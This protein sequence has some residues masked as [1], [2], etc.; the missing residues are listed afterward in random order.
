MNEVH[1][2]DGWVL[3]KFN[4][5]LKVFC[6]WSG[7]YLG[8]D[9]WRLNSKVRTVDMDEGTFVINSGGS[10]YRLSPDGYGRINVYTSGTLGGFENS[11]LKVLDEVDALM[12]LEVLL[13][14]AK[15]LV[16]DVDLEEPLSPEDD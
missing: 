14:R 1:R 11:G 5:D 9:S 6:S 13:R 12:Y 7:G 8:S 4:G 15:P 3:G 10:E 16:E 2:P